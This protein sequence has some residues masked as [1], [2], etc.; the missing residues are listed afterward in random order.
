MATLSSVI[1][2]IVTFQKIYQEVK[3]IVQLA[4]TGLKFDDLTIQAQGLVLL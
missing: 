4:D 3:A 1:S 2:L